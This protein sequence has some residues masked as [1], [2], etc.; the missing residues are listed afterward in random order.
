VAKPIKE[1]T[2]KQLEKGLLK[3]RREYGRSGSVAS[4]IRLEQFEAEVAARAEAA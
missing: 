2:A 4:I 3:A 1:M